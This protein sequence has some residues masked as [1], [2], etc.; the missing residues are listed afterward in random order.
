M[1]KEWI[2]KRRV[3][4][5][6]LLYVISKLAFYVGH[7][8]Y[9]NMRFLLLLILP[10]IRLLSQLQWTRNALS[11]P[12]VPIPSSTATTA[13]VQAFDSR[14]LFRGSVACYL[15]PALLNSGIRLNNLHPARDTARTGHLHIVATQ[16]SCDRWPIRS[17]RVSPVGLG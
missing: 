15:C 12:S 13:A 1:P 11:H 5:W 3:N 8:W 14:V 6:L 2:Y 4:C 9:Y 10:L 7:T 16:R 17:G